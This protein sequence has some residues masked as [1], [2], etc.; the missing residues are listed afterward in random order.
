MLRAFLD[1]AQADQGEFRLTPEQWEEF[2]ARLDDPPRVMPALSD[3]F[4]IKRKKK[5]ENKVP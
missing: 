5:T 1:A 2:C 4:S 3:L